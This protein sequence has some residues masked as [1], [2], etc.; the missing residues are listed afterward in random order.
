MTIIPE[1]KSVLP[2]ITLLESKT[3]LQKAIID[4]LELNGFSSNGV[5]TSEDLYKSLLVSSA[6]ILIVDVENLG[7]QG[8]A[9]IEFLSFMENM[10][11]IALCASDN[12]PCQLQAISAGASFNLINPVNIGLLAE[13]I[14]SVLRKKPFA[15][16]RKTRNSDHNKSWHLDKQNSVLISPDEHRL[17]LSIYELRLMT[18][19]LDAWD[20]SD[21]AVDKSAM[22]VYIYGSDSDNREKRLA[23]LLTR[24]RKRASN[25][26]GEDLPIR[27]SYLIGYSFVGKLILV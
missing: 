13:S 7:D 1:S 9:A 24:F 11:I 14:R 17:H 26:F 15:Q 10:T 27:T 12:I 20:K 18:M 6:D 19:L 23:L 22:S 16:L 4:G 8:I 3:D 25:L 5:S 21:G 2:I